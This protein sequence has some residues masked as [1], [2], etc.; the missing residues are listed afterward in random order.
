MSKLS[1]I[2]RFCASLLISALAL[3]CAAGPRKSSKDPVV[4]DRIAKAVV[5]GGE[6]WLRG[7]TGSGKGGSGGLISLNV[8]DGSKRVHFK[9]DVVDIQKA[10]GSFGCFGIPL[11]I[12]L[13]P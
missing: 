11:L 2:Q 4:G 6:L 8:S 3:P 13:L 9:N 7:A 12:K 5:F 10:G 1:V